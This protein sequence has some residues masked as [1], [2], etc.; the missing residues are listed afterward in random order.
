MASDPTSVASDI[1]KASGPTSVVSEMI[2]AYGLQ[3][4]QPTSGG[5]VTAVTNCCANCVELSRP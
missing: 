2:K 1:I 3:T 4:T 5:T